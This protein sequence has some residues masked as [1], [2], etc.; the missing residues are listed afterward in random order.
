VRYDLETSSNLHHPL[1][2]PYG[3]NLQIPLLKQLHTSHDKKDWFVPID[4]ADDTK[5]RKEASALA[6]IGGL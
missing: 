6:P 1:D 3:P 5:L 4:E 2:S